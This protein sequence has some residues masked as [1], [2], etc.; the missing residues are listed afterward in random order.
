MNAAMENDTD[1][2]ADKDRTIPSALGSLL[3]GTSAE[4]GDI[5]FLSNVRLQAGP[6]PELFVVSGASG[7]RILVSLETPKQSKLVPGNVDLRGTIRRLPGLEVLRKTWR[8]SK[9]QADFFGSEQF[10]IAAD[11]IKDQHRNATDE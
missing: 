10:Y 8:L 2:S 9:D 11:Y 4:V 1:F 5:V 7:T 6:K 3:V